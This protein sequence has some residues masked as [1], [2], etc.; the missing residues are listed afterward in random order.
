MT[1]QRIA[2]LFVFTL[3]AIASSGCAVPVERDG[4]GAMQQSYD[5]AERAPAK[6]EIFQG[7]DGQ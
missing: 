7:G 2:T 3:I 1:I 6:F 5:V 4:S